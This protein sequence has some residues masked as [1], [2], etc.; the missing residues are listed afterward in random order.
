M[1]FRV[2]KGEERENGKKWYLITDQES[3]KPYENYQDTNSRTFMNPK[4]D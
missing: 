4:Q 2:L 1:S 3:S